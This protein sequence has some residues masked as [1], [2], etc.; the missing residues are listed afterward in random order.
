MAIQSSS[1]SGGIFTV[2]NIEGLINDIGKGHTL[3][4]K[5]GSRAER[6][7]ATHQL[8]VVLNL[9]TIMMPDDQAKLRSLYRLREQLIE[10]NWGV[11]GDMLRPEK[12][13]RKPP[14]SIREAFKRAHLAA[15][16]H[17]KIEANRLAGG[18]GEKEKAARE[19]GTRFKVD[20]RKVDNW[21]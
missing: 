8:H 9:L 4:C 21:Q 2:H 13:G 1:P 19:V 17:L 15:T 7:G 3:Y 11:V 20:Y 5:G 16:M 6:V 12:R 14:I 18:R 10:L